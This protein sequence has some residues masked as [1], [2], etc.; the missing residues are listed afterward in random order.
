MAEFTFN[1]ELA[2]AVSEVEFEALDESLRDSVALRSVALGREDA[3][4]SAL[5]NVEA[6][7]G[8]AALSLAIPV[9]MNAHEQSGISS[10]G[11]F[12]KIDVEGPSF[13]KRLTVEP[14]PY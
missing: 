9:F 12:A 3:S 5:F 7:D 10:G 8:W 1:V 11:T 13:S 4:V 6:S 2:L 14:L